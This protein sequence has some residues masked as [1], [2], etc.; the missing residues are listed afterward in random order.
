MLVRNIVI[1]FILHLRRLLG[2]VVVVVLHVRKGAK[3]VAEKVNGGQNIYNRDASVG[4]G[5]NLKNKLSPL[6]DT[7]YMYIHNHMSLCT[8]VHIPF[9]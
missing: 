6:R 3:F 2:P 1:K 5:E 8:Y 4:I 9:Q 7:P